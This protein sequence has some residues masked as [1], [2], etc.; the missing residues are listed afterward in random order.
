MRIL[1]TTSQE[2]QVGFCVFKMERWSNQVAVVTGASSGIG[3]AVVENLVNND[4][5]VK[6]PL[7]YFFKN[8]LF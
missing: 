8:Q 2:V 6:Y 5:R 7:Y 4:I 1:F 3:A